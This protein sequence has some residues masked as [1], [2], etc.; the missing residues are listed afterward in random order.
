M[1]RKIDWKMKALGFVYSAVMTANRFLNPETVSAETDILTIC[2]GVGAE[3][4]IDFTPFP[5][6]MVNGILVNYGGAVAV[7]RENPMGFSYL[8]MYGYFDNVF[9]YAEIPDENTTPFIPRNGLVFV[10]GFYRVRDMPSGSVQDLKDS[11]PEVCYLKS[12]KEI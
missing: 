5:Q 11:A 8:N 12:S 3:A 1:E 4:N 7:V 2:L 9:N 6:V 10:P